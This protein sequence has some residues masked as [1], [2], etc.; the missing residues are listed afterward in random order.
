MLSGLE[1]LWYLFSVSKVPLLKIL[2]II[3]VFYQT[4]E[5][6]S[7]LHCIFSKVNVFAKYLI[8]VENHYFNSVHFVISKNSYQ[9]VQR[10]LGL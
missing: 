4:Q 9:N 2:A 10:L 3:H 7:Q 8:F 1:T 6:K 5:R